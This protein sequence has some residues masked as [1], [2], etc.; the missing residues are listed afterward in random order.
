MHRA[1]L[2]F[3]SYP[4]KKVLLFILFVFAITK[5]SYSQAD[6][7]RKDT[8]D[9]YDMTLEQLLSLKAHGVPT[10]MEALLNSMISVA[11]KKPLSTRESPSIIT[12]VT[13][14]EIKNSGARELIDVLR[15][16]PGIDFGV[17]VEGVVGI[18][19][20]GNWAHEGKLLLLIDGQEMNEILF[21][22]TQFGNHYPID[23][24]KR[25]EIIR[26]P[27]SAIY[28]GFAEYG[29]INIVTKKGEEL[30]GV[31]VS[32]IYGQMQGD[33]GH[34]NITMA[35][36]KKI[37]DFEYS[38]SGTVG[39]GNRSDQD[40]SDFDST[41][42]NLGGG[43]SKLDPAFFNLGMSYKGLSFR[44]IGDFCS[45]TVRDGYDVIKSNTY[46]ETYYGKYFELKYNW[47]INEKLTITPRL[48]FKQQDPWSTDEVDSLTPAYH[49][50]ANRYTGNLSASYNIN[51]YINVV[52]GGETFK[53]HAVDKVDSSY[54]TNGRTTVNYLNVAFFT[55]G[56]I[57]TR[58]VN[59]ILG[60]RYDKHN[61]Y[62]DAFVPRVGFTKKF[63]KFHFKALYSNA[64]RAP[65][66]EN[67]NAAYDGIIK[68]EKTQVIEIEAG[69]QVT[70]K[71]FL[72]MNFYDI[73]TKNP[74]V[75]YY[76]TIHFGDSYTNFGG[77]GTRGFE[78]EYRLKQKFGNININYAFY[79]AQGKE[80]IEDY[81]VPDNSAA[82]VGFA[83]HRVNL[84]AN[85]NLGKKFIISPTVSYY[86]NRSAYT[87]LDTSGTSVIEELSPVTLVNIFIRYTPVKGVSIGLGVYDLLDQK[88]AFV[89]PY[90][91]Y[92]APLH[93]PSREFI[94]KAQFDLNFKKKEKPKAE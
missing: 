70:R 92:H 53:D 5:F 24:I 87:S 90:N 79:T 1:S 25:I 48:N 49:K 8:L 35:I 28:G 60:A 18:G 89:Q 9:F 76:D 39:Q 71:S 58:L 57:K 65:A 68:P 19:I 43:N 31:S 29:V 83:N 52:F 80:S 75:Y 91:G 59:I 84:N 73:T 20:R 7:T 64:F 36:G 46:K 41:T 86:G 12:L 40:F 51:R 69:Y 3:N 26:G 30:N 17:D 15:L 61:V 94:L 14:E 32:G 78:L 82:M 81:A 38:L 22:T 42:Y 77:S 21:A 13:E 4:S 10:E 44:G 55:Q 67:I 34:R 63:K 23:Q 66:I 47:K 27:G 72:T 56:L 33:Y 45:T 37:G 85:F 54:F 62:G 74:I 6:T 16:V 88:F 11:S 50:T 93:G 2:I